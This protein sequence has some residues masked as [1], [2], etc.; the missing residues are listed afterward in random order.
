MRPW[1]WP[2]LVAVLATF[3]YV[4]R[5]HSE[6]VDF[7]VYHTAAARALD[8]EPLYRPDD[9]HYQFK[10]L[11]AFALAM[12]PFAAVPI[13]AARAGWFALSVVL[14]WF[15]VARAIERLPA[16]R[17]SAAVLAWIT[18]LL[19]GKFYAHELN[20]GQTNILLGLV[21]VLALAA[22]QKGQAARAG[23]LVGAAIFVKPYAAIL[24]PWLLPSAGVVAAAAAAAIIAVGL[25]APIV[26]YGWQGNLDQIVAWYRTVTDTTAPNLLQPENVSL[27]TMWAKWIGIGTPATILALITAVAAGV[28]VVWVVA[29]RGRVG[30]PAYLE[31]GLLML[32]VPLI[33][34]QGWDYVLLLATPA[35]L[36]L[37]DRYG[38]MTW[39]WRVGTGAAVALMSFTIFDVLGRAL[40]ARLMAVSVVTIAALV[41]LVSLAHLRRRALA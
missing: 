4:T 27:V 18:V 38:E 25:A 30:S 10:Y 11:P 23:A 13:E 29:R 35:M 6:M 37:V 19:M 39:R 34:P 2:T 12:A 22:V 33:S 3:M 15:F 26:T 40:Y 1:I 20:L 5:V 8:G 17:H 36:C 14:L 32:L 28:L 21:L 31:F 41:L 9:G 24:V 16:P 7:T